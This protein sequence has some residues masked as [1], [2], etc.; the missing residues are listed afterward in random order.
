M[1]TQQ[2]SR[3][4]YRLKCEKR[5]YLPSVIGLGI[6]PANA[7]SLNSWQSRPWYT[8]SSPRTRGALTQLNDGTFV[9]GIIP[10]DARSTDLG[11][12]YSRRIQDHPRGCGE[13][14]SGHAGLPLR[15]RGALLLQRVE[16]RRGGIIPA[17]AGSTDQL[18]KSLL[19][20]K[21]YPRG[22]GEHSAQQIYNVTNAKSSPRMWGAQAVDHQRGAIAGI[23]PADAGSTRSLPRARR[24]PQN[25]PRGCGEHVRLQ[26]VLFG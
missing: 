3:I 24:K 19:G 22:C 18:S 21:D 5:L 10:A 26:T 12:R 8:G 14:A 25:H 17:D 20:A 15:M 16:V 2:Q 6:I 4:A 7:W 9:V 11:A 23:I 13:H 1:E